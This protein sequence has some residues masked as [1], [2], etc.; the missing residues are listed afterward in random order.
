MSDAG[1]P[2]I[3]MFF[4]LARFTVESIG[5]CALQQFLFLR[6]PNLRG[7]HIDTHAV[8]GAQKGKE[9]FRIVD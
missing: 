4:G 8:E 2:P 1:E 7:S 6:H 5:T 3:S 9:L